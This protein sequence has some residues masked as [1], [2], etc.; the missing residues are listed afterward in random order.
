MRLRVAVQQQQRRAAAPMRPCSATPSR[1][2]S[3]G[4]KPSSTARL[5]VAGR[6]ASSNNHQLIISMA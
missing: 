5:C 6:T 1:D 4:V 2:M 3:K